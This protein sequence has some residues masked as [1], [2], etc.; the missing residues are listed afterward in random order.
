MCLFDR[1]MALLDQL[2]Q[3]VVKCLVISLLYIEEELY[4]FLFISG[5]SNL[6]PRSQIIFCGPLHESKAWRLC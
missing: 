6:R 5:S 1:Q 3:F 2:K 4:I